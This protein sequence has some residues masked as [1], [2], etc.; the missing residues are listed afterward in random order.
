MDLS[1]AAALAFDLFPG[2]FA[3]RHT[4]EGGAF[5]EPFEIDIEGARAIKSAEGADAVT[6]PAEE[7]GEFGARG[8]ASGGFQFGGGLEA[9]GDGAGGRGIGV[10]GENDGGCGGFPDGLRG[11]VEI[12]LFGAFELGAAAAGAKPLLGEAAEGGAEVDES[13]LV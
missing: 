1:G 3:A 8:E 4:D 2:E 7:D 9:H 12:E 11:A 5:A 13:G 6:E 10:E